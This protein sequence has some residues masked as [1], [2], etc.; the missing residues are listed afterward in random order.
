MERRQHPRIKINNP[1]IVVSDGMG[2]SQGLVSD[3]SASGMQINNL[4]QRL[5]LEGNQLSVILSEDTKLFRMNV[6]PKWH[7][8][9][10]GR[11]SMGVEIMNF[12]LRWKEFIQ[13]Y[14][15]RPACL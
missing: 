12:P 8:E 7:R 4:P 15:N 9:K 2:P 13:K 10:D 3:I 6:T 14:E 5:N 11:I 1:F